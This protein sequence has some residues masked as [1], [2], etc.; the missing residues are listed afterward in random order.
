M[1]RG[2]S[3]QRLLLQKQIFVEAVC[4]DVVVCDSHPTVTRFWQFTDAVNRMLRAALFAPPDQLFVLSRIHPLPRQAKRL[5]LV[6][7]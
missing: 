1:V 6:K 3:E 2:G 4:K 7:S 5:Q